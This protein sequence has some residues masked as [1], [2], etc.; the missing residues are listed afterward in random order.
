VLPGSALCRRCVRE[1]T[2]STLAALSVRQ[3]HLSDEVLALPEQ[4][5]AVLTRL[6]EREGDRIAAMEAFAAADPGGRADYDKVS[7]ESRESLAVLAVLSKLVMG[8]RHAV[9][10][11]QGKS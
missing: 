11:I 2:I 9:E 4:C 3:S 7:A 6:A 8:H 5:L 1:P 10:K